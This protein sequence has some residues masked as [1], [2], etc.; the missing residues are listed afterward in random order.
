MSIFKTSTP[1]VDDKTVG[2]IYGKAQTL[3]SADTLNLPL[4]L[5]LK[6]DSELVHRLLADYID[7]QVGAP[8][9]LVKAHLAG[10]QAD[11]RNDEQELREMMED[12]TPRIVEAIR[13]AADTAIRS[14]LPSFKPKTSPYVG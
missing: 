6:Q 9:A 14:E 4:Q 11:V 3:L 7:T 13:K 5:A 8:K 10:T 12:H 1:P 2:E